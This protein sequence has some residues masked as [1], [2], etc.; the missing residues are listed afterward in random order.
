MIGCEDRV[1]NLVDSAIVEKENVEILRMSGH[2]PSIGSIE[3]MDPQLI[4]VGIQMPNLKGLDKVFH[5]SAS[6]LLQTVPVIV[7]ADGKPSLKDVDT[8]LD[9]GAVDVLDKSIDRTHLIVRIKT[10]LVRTKK[11]MN[12]RESEE[13]VRKS[14]SELYETL[15]TLKKQV[16]NKQRESKAQLELLVHSKE[17]NEALMDKLNDLKP[18]LNSEGKS[19]LN[20]ISKQIRWEVND[21]EI[22]NVERRL[23]IENDAFYHALED[24]CPELTKY[25]KR[26][27]A[28]FRT[29]QSAASIARIMRKTS[30]C[31]NVAFAR[32]RAKMEIKNN[33]ELKVFLK[34]IYSNSISQ[35][36]A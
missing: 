30:N 8:I 31:I 12:L 34:D 1:A 15:E 32:I 5:I 3:L 24:V 7:F 13:R 28:Y 18:Y 20:F 10:N 35:P 21:Q 17:V 14:T 36:A 19:K 29:N 9:A 26:L 27:C 4:M 11:L 25:E 2:K 22:I 16:D 33:K 23:D 6:P